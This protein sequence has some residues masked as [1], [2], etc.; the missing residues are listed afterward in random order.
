MA[1]KKRHDFF[2][3]LIFIPRICRNSKLFFNYFITQSSSEFR[4]S[5]YFRKD[6]FLIH[7][8]NANAL[9][10]I[11]Y[12]LAYIYVV[13]LH[14]STYTG[15]LEVHVQYIQLL[16]SNVDFHIHNNYGYLPSYLLRYCWCLSLCNS[17]HINN[18]HYLNYRYINSI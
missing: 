7:L 10:I 5:I 14:R 11:L 4:I 3:H 12:V 6:F 15:L 18:L 9:T 1:L 17:F 2:P 13:Q 16:D 8:P